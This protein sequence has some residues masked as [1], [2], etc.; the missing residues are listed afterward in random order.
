[1]RVTPPAAR[2]LGSKPLAHHV[3]G[4]KLRSATAFPHNTRF[5]AI[6][7]DPALSGW[8]LVLPGFGR[9]PPATRRNSRRALHQRV[10]LRCRSGHGQCGGSLLPPSL[11]RSSTASGARTNANGILA[12]L[13]RRTQVLLL[14][15]QAPGII[16]D[17]AVKLSLPSWER[18]SKRCR[19]AL[20][21]EPAALFVVVA[22]PIL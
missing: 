9:A 10:R 21:Q 7:S 14:D 2:Q 20:P 1:M 16:F 15:L 11:R 17:E 19:T 13:R 3:R 5:Y 22:N 18:G 8:Q 6:G 4:S 12:N